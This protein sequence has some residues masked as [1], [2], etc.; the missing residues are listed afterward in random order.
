MEGIGNS[1]T[2][3]EKSFILWVRPRLARPGPG[4]GNSC[5]EPSFFPPSS[6]HLLQLLFVLLL[7]LL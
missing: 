5:A 2:M 6:S 7:V 1:Q 3:V 4:L